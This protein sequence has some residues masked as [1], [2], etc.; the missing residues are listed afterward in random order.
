MA[1]NDDGTT[2]TLPYLCTLALP[3]LARSCPD[4]PLIVVVPGGVGVVC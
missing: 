2:L 3:R 4:V 1:E